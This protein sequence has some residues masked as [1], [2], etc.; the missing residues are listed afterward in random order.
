MAPAQT[1]TSGWWAMASRSADTSPVISDPRCTPPIP[2][3]ANT[4]TP[5]A[6]AR[7]SD[8]DT[9][10]APR[11][12]RCAR[13]TGTSRSAALRAGPRMRACSC[14]ATPTRATPSS[15]AVTAGTAPAARMAPVQRSSASALAGDGNPRWEKM[16]DSSATTARP[17]ARA[18]ATSGD[19]TGSIT[20][21]VCRQR[22]TSR[23]TASM[24]V[25]CGNVSTSSVR[26][27]S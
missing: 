27:W 26:S 25:V 10:V 24:W 2:P 23:V 13:A 6:A 20:A 4:D 1:V 3:V 5:A 21:A 9:V 7:A 15:T 18:A 19:T 14:S 17:S 22:R 16:V 8:A 11:S 12:Q